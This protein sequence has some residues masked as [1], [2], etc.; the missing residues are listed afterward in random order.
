MI[1]RL[2]LLVLALLFTPAYLFAQESIVYECS[3]KSPIK[4]SLLKDA[5]EKATANK[6]AI[7]FIKEAMPC[8]HTRWITD[9]LNRTINKR[10]F[11]QATIHYFSL[12]KDGELSFSIE[13]FVFK[14][15]N[16]VTLITKA[17][18]A[19][20]TRTLHLKA[21]TFYDYFQVENNLIFFIADRESYKVNKDLFDLIKD[22]FQIEYRISNADSNDRMKRCK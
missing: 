7:Q 3:I 5:I 8:T 10:F 13:R 17:L 11:N 22:R 12:I 19:R 2:T 4:D 21:L 15:K 16:T 18:K 6:Q 1:L 20:T 14:D 9:V